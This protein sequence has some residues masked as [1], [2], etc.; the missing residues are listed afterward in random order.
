MFLLF[1]IAFVEIALMGVV[2]TWDVLHPRLM[3]NDGGARKKRRRP[4]RVTVPP[5]RTP[6]GLYRAANCRNSAVSLEPEAGP[7]CHAQVVI[8]V[9]VVPVDLVAC[10]GADAKGPEEHFEAATG[11]DRKM[12]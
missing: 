2:I 11:V 6:I 5:F 1:I 8:R 4:A 12:R 3:S 10:F 9:A 7:N